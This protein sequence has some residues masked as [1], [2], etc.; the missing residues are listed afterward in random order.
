MLC[1]I[2]I[3][4]NTI[5]NEIPISLIAAV[6]LFILINDVFFWNADLNILSR[7][8]GMILCTLFIGFMI[9][10]FKS[11]KREAPKEDENDIKMYPTGTSILLAV[12]GLGMLVGGGKLVVDSAVTIAVSFGLSEK[13]IGLTI[14][15]I[16]TSLPEL[17][18]SAVAAY[19]KNP[20]IA[21][22]NV[23]GSNIF[24]ILF[25]LGLTPIIQP[26]KYNTVLNP[27]ILMLICGTVLLI[28]FMFT[29]R[30]RMLDRSEA[31]ILLMVYTGYT[32]Y[33]I[34]TDT[35]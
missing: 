7:Y 21:I 19:K 6:I 9:Y 1:P 32:L 18:T 15:A 29:F 22:G 27:D 23:V 30:K 16:G 24:N 3:Q 17:A 4:K 2:V 34:F 5:K 13:L 28:I 31:F 35:P 12:L 25:I 8:D 10:V 11:M 14:L 33:L 20:D 26:L